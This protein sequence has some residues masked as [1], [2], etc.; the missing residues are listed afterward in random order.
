MALKCGLLL[1]A[2]AGVPDAG[3]RGGGLLWGHLT[4]E[5]WLCL[6]TL[7]FPAEH[8]TG[9]EQTRVKVGL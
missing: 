6:Q 1:A 8:G 5:A 9:E 7:P 3:E 2:G 4:Q